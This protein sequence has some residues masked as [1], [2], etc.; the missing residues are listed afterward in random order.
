MSARDKLIAILTAQGGR[1]PLLEAV[2][3][4]VL[5][6]YAAELAENLRAEVYA[7]RVCVSERDGMLTAACFVQY[8]AMP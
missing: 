8:G 2:A 6:E 4:E 5:D 7:G 3:D 1:V